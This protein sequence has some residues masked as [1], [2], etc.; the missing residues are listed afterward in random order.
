MNKNEP[1]LYLLKNLRINCPKLST[2]KVSEETNG[3][4]YSAR[5]SFAKNHEENAEE[6]NKAIHNAM[7]D[8]TWDN[9]F[10]GNISLP[11]LDGDKTGDLTKNPELKGCW[12]FTA[13]SNDPVRVFDKNLYECRTPEEIEDVIYPGAICS[14]VIY[15]EAYEQNG[16][17]GVDLRLRAVRK[18]KDWAR[19]DEK[20]GEGT[21]EYIDDEDTT[22]GELFTSAA[23]VAAMED[24]QWD[25]L[26]NMDIDDEF[27]E[28]EQNESEELEKSSI[29]EESEE[30][31]ILARYP[32]DKIEWALEQAILQNQSKRLI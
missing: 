32:A 20:T 8:K 18:S 28:I 12:Y 1:K 9:I 14:A 2:L 21:N 7:A 15:A 24:N 31:N 25:E 17:K 10:T 26:F 27:P 5:F 30:F 16:E 19:L 22:V 29:D 3:S 6:L 23:A 13:A 11:I 4:Q